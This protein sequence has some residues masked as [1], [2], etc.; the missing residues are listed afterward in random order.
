VLWDNNGITI[1]GKVSLADRTDQMERFAASGWDVFECDGHDPDDIDRAL[2]AAK[3]S[4]KPAM[5]ACKT[6]IALGHAAQ[7]T[8]KGHGA[9]TDADQLA[10]A[11]KA[12]GWPHGPFEVPPTSRRSG[13]P[14]APAAP[15]SARSGRRASRS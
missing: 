6:H 9:L 11:K 12:Y 2:T 13:R 7:D 8:A 4:G 14:S 10:A 1:D 3:A 5:I 15:P